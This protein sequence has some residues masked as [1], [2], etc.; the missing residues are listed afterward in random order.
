MML[1]QPSW[2]CV[3][4]QV[5]VGEGADLLGTV[6]FAELVTPPERYGLYTTCYN[7]CNRWRKAGVW[8]RIMDAV[9]EAYDGDIQII[10]SSMVRV[11][12]YAGNVKITTKCTLWAVVEED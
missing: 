7:H 1:R 12:Q 10:D 2:S 4:I 3:E 6:N 5:L 8:D 9:S 11:H